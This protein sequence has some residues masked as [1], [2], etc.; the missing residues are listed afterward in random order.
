MDLFD[1]QA[2]TASG[3]PELAANAPLAV[4][5]AAPRALEEVVGQAHLLADGSPFVR[6]IGPDASATSLILWG[7]PGTGKTTLA[8]LVAGNRRFVELS[9]VTAGIKDVRAVIDDSKRRIATGERETVL[10]IDEIHRFTRTQQDA[11]L[12]AVEN[13]WVTLIGATTENPS[14]SVV[15]PLL[16]RSLLLT[17]KPLTEA[18]VLSLVDRAIADERGLAGAVTVEPEAKSHVVR[19]AGAD[20]RKALTLLERSP[21]RA[22]RRHRPDGTRGTGHG[23]AVV[24]YDRQG[25]QH[26]DVIS[27]FIKSVRG[28]DV[29]ASLHYLARIDVAGEVARFIARRLVILAAEGVGL[30]ESA[31][32]G[33]G[34]GRGGRGELH[35]HARGA[36]RARGGNRVPSTHTQVEPLLRG[37]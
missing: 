25:D 33:R 32:L 37:D 22:A 21:T 35:R 36:H 34:A 1:A 8:Y 11:L 9:A 15:G 5:H 4:A 26:Y 19:V 23:A 30:A 31:R 16:S 12:P 10:F 27:A 6:L 20:A 17:L 3:V 29:D 13:R 2:T 24:A 18:D 28:S 14:F 7:P